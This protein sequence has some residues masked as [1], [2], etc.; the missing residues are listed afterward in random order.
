MVPAAEQAERVFVALSLG[1][2]P[3]ALTQELA[4]EGWKLDGKLVNDSAPG[5]A[6]LMWSVWNLTP[7]NR[8]SAGLQFCLSPPAGQQVGRSPPADGR[9]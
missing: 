9:R 1:A 5:G 6:G 4:G 3:A 8:P 2:E 7:S